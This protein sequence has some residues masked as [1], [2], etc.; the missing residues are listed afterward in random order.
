MFAALQTQKE[1]NHIGQY[2]II[3]F[4]RLSWD[5]Y[6]QLFLMNKL[7]IDTFHDNKK[8]N[9]QGAPNN[10]FLY[11]FI[12]TIWHITI[13]FFHPIPTK[14]KQA[15]LKMTKWPHLWFSCGYAGLEMGTGSTLK[16]IKMII[17]FSKCTIECLSSCNVC[18]SEKLMQQREPI[19]SIGTL[20]HAEKAACKCLA[21]LKYLQKIHSKLAIYRMSSEAVIVVP[22]GWK[23]A[24]GCRL[25]CLNTTPNSSPLMFY[26]VDYATLLNLQIGQLRHSYSDV[27]FYM[28]C[29][30]LE[31]KAWQL[32]QRNFVE[33]SIC[34][35]LHCSD[36]RSLCGCKFFRSLEFFSLHFFRT[37]QSHSNNN[38]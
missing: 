29:W 7:Q 5:F 36:T 6:G 34:F 24:Y 3:R 15:W 19:C 8:R 4:H 14:I 35:G 31:E 32:A 25:L 16:P 12:R 22:Q 33:T 28:Q 37:L 1:K 38:K 9:L 26:T 23:V 11:K 17:S 13:L 27:P 21:L 30:L 2:F 18:A 20:L 10:K